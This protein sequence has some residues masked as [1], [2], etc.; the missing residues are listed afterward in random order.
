MN[1]LL[2]VFIFFH[3]PKPL[4]SI[5]AS[6]L[7][8][9][10]IVPYISVN[11]VYGDTKSEKDTSANRL[12]ADTLT[13]RFEHIYRINSRQLKI[14]NYN[15]AWEIRREIANTFTKA[16]NLNGGFAKPNKTFYNTAQ[17]PPNLKQAL[18][19][20]KAKFGIVFVCDAFYHAQQ[21]QKEL[22]KQAIQSSIAETVFYNLLFGPSIYI[23]IP[24][25]GKI[26]LET[27]IYDIEKNK[28]VFLNAQYYEGSL[29]MNKL[30]RQF[31]DQFQN[32]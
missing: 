9:A 4:T 31:D 3:T 10:I 13:N 5:S 30:I 23:K 21:Y 1:L 11:R 2:T 32:F 7:K 6:D 20:N 25:R 17:I 26:M 8:D 15:Q 19:S 22:N 14:H 18:Q 16:I 28:V 24:I 29:D 27:I 12:I